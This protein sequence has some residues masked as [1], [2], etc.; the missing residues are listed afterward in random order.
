MLEDEWEK[1]S[2]ILEEDFCVELVEEARRAL[3]V[4][5]ESENVSRLNWYPAEWWDQISL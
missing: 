4:H 1:T 5:N 2:W 3:K